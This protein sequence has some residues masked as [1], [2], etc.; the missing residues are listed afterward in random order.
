MFGS[1]TPISYDWGERFAHSPIAG[2]IMNRGDF[3]D[4]AFAFIIE[5]EQ[6]ELA[7]DPGAKK[8]AE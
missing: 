3:V 2:F 7:H 4:R 8:I 6:F 1:M 5:R